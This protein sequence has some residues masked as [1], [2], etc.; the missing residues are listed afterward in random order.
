MPKIKKLDQDLINKIAAG[1]VVERPA[2]VVKELIENS[3][4][5]GAKNIAVEIEKGG[6][7]LIKVADDGLGM[8]RDDALLSIERHTTSKIGNI[9]DLFNIHTLGFRGEALASI[10][11]VSRFRLQTKQKEDLVGTEIIFENEKIKSKDIGCK[12]GTA[13]IVEDLFYNVPARQKFLKAETTEFNHI[14][15]LFND[16]VL[17]YNNIGWKLYH[18]KKLIFNF[19]HNLD[20]AE[21]IRAILGND[22]SKD[23]LPIS[24]DGWELKISGFVSKPAVTR[25]N[26]KSQ[27][28]FVNNR[29]VKDYLVSLAVKEAFN[30]LI[31][32]DQY[33]VFVFKVDVDPKLVDVN[34]HPRKSEVKFVDTKLIYN[35]VYN[36]VSQVVFSGNEPVMADVKTN[37]SYKKREFGSIDQAM[38]FTQKIM[39]NQG[40]SGLRPYGPIGPEGEI[41]GYQGLSRDIRGDQGILGDIKGYQG[42][43]RGEAVLGDWKLIGQIKNSYL[44]VESNDGLIIIDQH[45]AAERIL[46]EKLKNETKKTKPPSQNLFLPIDFELSIREVNLLEDNKNLLQSLGFSIENFGGNSFVVNAVPQELSQYEIKPIILGVVNDLEEPEFKNLKSVEEKQD[47]VTK[48]TACR[49]AVKFNDQLNPEEQIQLL[50]DIKKYNVISCPHGRP[51]LWVIEWGDLEKKFRR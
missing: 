30:N 46:Y 38:R 36:M 26:K 17:L 50:R 9:D 41:R 1:E 18:N 28:V 49:G 5:A 37:P 8:S 12:D 22:V 14:L 2:S 24:F 4:D 23:L 34:V 44:L 43:S 3:L 21:R 32:K 40:I 6:A 48:Y 25:N 47:I 29:P 35:A 11:A 19:S 27:F 51:C 31:P 39:G 13:V 7:K 42:V 15:D 20:W 16:Y 45:A 10:S 33:P